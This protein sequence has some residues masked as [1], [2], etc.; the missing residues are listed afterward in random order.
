MSANAILS[1]HRDIAWCAKL[2]K[3]L[4]LAAVIGVVWVWRMAMVV[5]L[6]IWI[7]GIHQALL[8]RCGACWVMDI[9]STCITE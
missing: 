4:I 6:E 9:I 3:F 7:S 5:A 8:V 1:H 2:A